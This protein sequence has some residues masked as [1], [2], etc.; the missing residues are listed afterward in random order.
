M[1]I[2]RELLANWFIDKITNKILENEIKKLYEY[3]W[4]LYK[5]N[6]TENVKILEYWENEFF[7]WKKEVFEEVLELMKKYKI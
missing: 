1:K 6:L 7:W 4:K 5:E 3:Y 2:T